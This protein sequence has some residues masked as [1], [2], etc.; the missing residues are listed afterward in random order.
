MVAPAAEASVPRCRGPQQGQIVRAELSRS[1]DRSMIDRSAVDRSE[2]IPVVPSW[3][4][5]QVAVPYRDPRVGMVE[6]GESMSEPARTGRAECRLVLHSCGHPF[7]KDTLEEEAIV[8]GVQPP[9][10]GHRLHAHTRSPALLDHEIW[11]V[12]PCPPI[13]PLVSVERI[14]ERA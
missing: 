5:Q 14:E 6:L 13:T 9:R 3:Q 7:A 4:Q 1:A 11:S 8:G 2:R 10:C 12:R